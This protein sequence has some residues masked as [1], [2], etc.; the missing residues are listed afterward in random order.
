MSTR[1]WESDLIPDESVRAANAFE[2]EMKL[3]LEDK[4][5]AVRSGAP[6]SGKNFEIN[7]ALI[8]F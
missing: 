6:I 3:D 7:M 5:Q 1:F 2:L 4:V 8:I